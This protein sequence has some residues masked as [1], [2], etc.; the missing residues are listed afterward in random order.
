MLK[1][2]GGIV[3]A[4]VEAGRLSGCPSLSGAR[5]WSL[6]APSLPVF[7]RVLCRVLTSPLDGPGLDFGP[8]SAARWVY[9]VIALKS[10]VYASDGIVVLPASLSIHVTEVEAAESLLLEGYV[11]RHFCIDEALVL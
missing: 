11:A 2:P 3:K 9:F 8:S 6:S 4:R 7:W 5:P 10:K 1:E